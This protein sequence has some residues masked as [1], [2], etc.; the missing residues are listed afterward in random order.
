MDIP[1]QHKELEAKRL[2]EQK[3]LEQEAELRRVQ[4]EK[5]Q[6]LRDRHAVNNRQIQQIKALLKKILRQRAL[7][8]DLGP[9]KLL[10]PFIITKL[11]VR[12]WNFLIMVENDIWFYYFS[13][14]DDKEK[15]TF[16]KK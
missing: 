16:L 15:K 14:E 4:E 3:Q 5:L 12:S 10:G 6:E 9:S 7:K 8:I 2:Q 11:W 13:T 1:K